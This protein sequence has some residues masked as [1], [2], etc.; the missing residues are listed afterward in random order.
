MGAGQRVLRP[1]ARLHPERLAAPVLPAA[2]AHGAPPAHLPPRHRRRVRHVG[3]VPR[4]ADTAR[5]ADQGGGDGGPRGRRGAVAAR[6]EPPHEAGLELPVGG[7]AARGA[8]RAA[9]HPAQVRA[10]GPHRARAGPRLGH[11]DG[12]P[13][14]HPPQLGARPAPPGPEPALLPGHGP[15][16][17]DSSLPGGHGLDAEERVSERPL[18][19]LPRPPALRV[20]AAPQDHRLRVPR[21]HHA[22]V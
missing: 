4:G 5:A 18:G 21:Q 9:G 3:A 17:P 20:R 2:A 10:Q 14:V 7:H 16:L 6:H 11:A 8:R 19:R 1:V 22:R 13:P 12:L 15:H